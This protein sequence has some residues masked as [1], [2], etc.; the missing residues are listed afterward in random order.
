MIETL[1]PLF[2]SAALVTIRLTLWG[3][4]L[5]FFVGV[6]GNLVYFYKIPGLTWLMGAYTELSRNTP[7]LAHLFFL[8]FGLPMLGINLSGFACGVIGLTFL[9]GS[10]MMEAIRGGVEAVAKTQRESALSLGLSRSQMLWYVIL[11]QAFRTA[12][13]ALAANVIFLLRESAL[14]SVIAVPE[15]M[16]MARS[17]IGMFFRT[18]EVL[19]MLTLYYLVLIAP[20]SLFFYLLEKRV[21]LGSKVRTRPSRLRLL[22]G[23][24]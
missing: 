5:A 3:V 18:D 4:L 23:R 9:G 7:L 12:L 11:P 6:I 2:N 20:L 10:Y 17:Q 22:K 15:L 13:S 1:V 21:R 24:G 19:I 16:H 14:V 8:F